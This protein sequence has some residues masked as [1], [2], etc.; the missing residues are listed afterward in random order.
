VLTF[1]AQPDESASE[2]QEALIAAV[3]FLKPREDT[4]IM[5]DLV[6]KAL[7][8]MAL[9]VQILVIGTQCPAV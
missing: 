7:N 2:M 5:F 1:S 9:L 3:V 8:Q 4:T 6:D